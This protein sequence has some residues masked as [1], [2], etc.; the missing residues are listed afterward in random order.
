L[1]IV[2]VTKTV[3]VAVRTG[4]SRLDGDGLPIAKPIEAVE[5]DVPV[6]L[7]EDDGVGAFAC[8]PDSDA[9]PAM[10]A[11]IVTANPRWRNTR[12]SLPLAATREEQ[13]SM[14]HAIS[15]IVQ[16]TDWIRSRALG[17]GIQATSTVDTGCWGTALG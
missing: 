16:S 5:P 3:G 15:A 10:T 11:D 14:Y 13:Q 9:Q 12:M 17:L 1:V 2:G 8:P 6:G 4:V 7:G